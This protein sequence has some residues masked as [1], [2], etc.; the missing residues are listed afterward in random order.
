MHDVGMPHQLYEDAMWQ[1]GG[2]HLI[3]VLSVENPRQTRP[4]TRM[5]P[6]NMVKYLDITLM[7]LATMTWRPTV[8]GGVEN[9]VQRRE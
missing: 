6:E 2:C 3:T 7:S 5:H 4:Y 9:N 1:L 8:P